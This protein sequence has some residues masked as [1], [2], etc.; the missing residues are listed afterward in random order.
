M[1]KWKLFFI[2]IVIEFYKFYPFFLFNFCL[3]ILTINTFKSIQIST[4]INKKKSCKNIFFDL[5]MDEFIH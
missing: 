4:K 5:I 2:I 3:S 1:I